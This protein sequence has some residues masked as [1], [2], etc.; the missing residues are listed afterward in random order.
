MATARDAII[1]YATPIRRRPLRPIYFKLLLMTLVPAFAIWGW[2]FFI[3]PTFEE[4]FKSFPGE[5]PE[6]TRYIFVTTDQ[7]RSVICLPLHVI[8]LGL[9]PLVLA[10]VAHKGEEKTERLILSLYFALIL[11]FMIGS[12]GCIVIG[13]TFPAGLHERIS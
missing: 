6:L 2:L 8:I 1:A 7:A 4:V 13:I 3:A 10:V 5:M 9:M 11:L 12:V